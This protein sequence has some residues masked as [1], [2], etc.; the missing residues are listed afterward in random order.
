MSTKEVRTCRNLVEMTRFDL[1]IHD[2]RVSGDVFF[3]CNRQTEADELAGTC[4]STFFYSCWWEWAWYPSSW[5]SWK[6]RRLRSSSSTARQWAQINLCG[7]CCA[8]ESKKKRF[9]TYSI[10][11]LDMLVE[12][13]ERK[14]DW[15]VKWCYLVYVLLSDHSRKVRNCLRKHSYIWMSQLVKWSSCH[16][17]SNARTM[18]LA[19]SRK[20]HVWT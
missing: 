19:T 11:I 3:F 14:M 5:T 20:S 17:R 7:D 18:D 8:A 1:E 13:Q 15:N 9:I 10:L 16:R 2:F 4:M 12:R 6:R